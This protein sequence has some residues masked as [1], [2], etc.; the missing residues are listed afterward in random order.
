MDVPSCRPSR[1]SVALSR[2]SCIV[3]SVL[4]NL[5]GIRQRVHASIT[6]EVELRV[7]LDAEDT[8]SED[9]VRDTWAARTYA[10]LRD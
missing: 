1:P 10:H 2:W 8:D 4:L 6:T 7:A 9:L 3:A 5:L